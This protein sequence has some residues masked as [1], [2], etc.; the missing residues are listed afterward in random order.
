MERERG[1][2]EA[3]R[4]G[5]RAGCEAGLAGPHEQPEHLEPALL[6]EGGEGVHDVALIHHSSKFIES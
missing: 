3:E 4:P 6:G 2:R 5:D 1:C